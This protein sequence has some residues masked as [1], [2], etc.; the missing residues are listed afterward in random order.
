MF[1]KTKIILGVVLTILLSLFS[2]NIYCYFFYNSEP[3]LSVSGIEDTGHYQGE[4]PVIV[5][6]N[7][8]YKVSDVSIW[9]DGKNLVN[10]HKISRKNFE[11]NFPLSTKTLANGK[12]NL[13]IEITNSIFNKKS[14]A[15]E[16]NFYVDNNPLQA[17]FLKA[18]TDF[19][20]FQGRTLHVQFQTNKELKE[21]RAK[22]FSKE[23]E[24]FSES[25]NS[26]IYECFVPISCEENPNEY[27]LAIDLLDKVGNNLTLNMKFQI[28]PFPFKKQTV[29]ISQEK[30]KLEEEA[31][32]SEKKL[33]EVLAELT[34]QSPKQKLWQG[35]FYPP[36][37]IKAVTTDFGTV[38]TTQF[39]GLY[40]HKAVDV[41]N[42]PKSVIWAP[43]EGI[44]VCKD[45]F[46]HSG[47]TI[48][49]DHGHGILSM[50]FHLDNFANLQ[51]GDKVRRGNPIGTLGMTGHA[52]GYHLHW[53][54][55]INNIAIDPMQWTKPNF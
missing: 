19:K 17:A 46:A 26:V 14:A 40:A 13:K 39:R 12:H 30:L 8:A 55:R 29:K 3:Q 31:G 50:F 18:D 16:L 25:Q 47:N 49:L 48:I 20:V 5:T 38:R 1:S 4:V 41:I 34:K 51:V 2:W 37:E 42:T 32:H 36:T 45:R 52:T 9:L 15:K 33:E 27:L 24:C 7:D 44:V 43:Q 53:E 22:T 23:F 10:H 28:I 54:M 6:G 35:A 21:A 11:Y